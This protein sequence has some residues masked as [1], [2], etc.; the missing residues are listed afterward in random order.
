M[1]ARRGMFWQSQNYNNRLVMMYRNMIVQMAMSR[2]R[3][4]NLPP[5]CSERFLEW[6]LL[7][8]GVACICF[9]ESQPGTFY[10]TRAQFQ[11][12][13]NVY[14]DFPTW[15]SVGNGGWKFSADVTQ[16]TLVWDNATRFPLM[17]GI[18]IKAQEL[19]HIQLT[20]E[21]NRFHQQIP[22]ILK[23]PK[24]RQMDMQNITKQVAGGEQ[25]IIAF[26]GFD[27]I[28]VDTIN[29]QVPF[30]GELLAQDEKNCWNGVYHLLGIENSPMKRE[31]QTEDE[32]QAMKSPT[33]LIRMNS[34]DERRRAADYLNDHFSEYLIQGPIK[35]VWREDN[36]SANWNL[37]HNDRALMQAVG[38]M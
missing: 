1:N 14:D 5:T 12:Q 37:M 17:S 35:V 18:E 36:E 13:P 6:T 25:A 4:L 26:D 3:W 15:N 10:S 11:S 8:E 24:S 31:R 33:E 19:A 38:E 23:G 22:W 9:P 16:G 20:K 30:L 27:E 32:I 34:L 29:T 2:F 28:E 7:Y 21:M